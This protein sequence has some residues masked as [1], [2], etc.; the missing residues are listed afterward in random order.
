MPCFGQFLISTSNGILTKV[1]DFLKEILNFET[2]FCRNSPKIPVFLRKLKLFTQINPYQSFC[3][4][5][6]SRVSAASMQSFKMRPPVH[7]HNLFY[8][9]HLQPYLRAK[10][11]A[12]VQEGG[13]ERTR[14]PVVIVIKLR[15]SKQYGSKHYKKITKPVSPAVSHFYICDFIIHFFLSAV[16]TFSDYTLYQFT[17]CTS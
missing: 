13:E 4:P 2:F 12:G 15:Q 17:P 9:M 6:I 8:A 11:W 10:D 14:Q 3:F 7:G 16:N 5:R 1:S